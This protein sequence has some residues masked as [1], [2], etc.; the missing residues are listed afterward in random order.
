MVQVTVAWMDVLLVVSLVAVMDI[1]S[2]VV[3]AAR[4]DELMVEM[5]EVL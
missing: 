4:L 1:S 3:R 5:M 2:V